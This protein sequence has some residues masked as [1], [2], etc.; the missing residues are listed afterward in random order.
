MAR[1]AAYGAFHR[2]QTI[3]LPFD[4]VIGCG[5]LPRPDGRFVEP[6]YT[7]AEIAAP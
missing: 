2:E 7:R 3:T 5:P 4:F 6:G 1:Y